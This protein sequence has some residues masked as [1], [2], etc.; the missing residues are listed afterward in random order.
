MFHLGTIEAQ[1]CPTQLSKVLSCASFEE[2]GSHLKF[3]R[4]RLLA[5]L[6]K[7]INAEVRGGGRREVNSTLPF[8]THR[9]QA[10]REEQVG[11]AEVGIR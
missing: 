10:A 2:K 1:L 9:Q 8:V 7:A 11:E 4:P 6:G 5:G 3:G